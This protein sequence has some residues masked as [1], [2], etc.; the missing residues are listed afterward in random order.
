MRRKAPGI[1]AALALLA[2]GGCSIL[3]GSDGRHASLHP[4][5]CLRSSVW[6]YSDWTGERGPREVELGDLGIGGLAAFDG[7]PE[8]DDCSLMRVSTVLGRRVMTLDPVAID[9]R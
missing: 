8:D 5:S 7:K 4:A 3:P 1:V 6:D 2:A 9:A